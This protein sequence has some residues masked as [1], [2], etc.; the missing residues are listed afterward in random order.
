[1]PRSRS[2]LRLHDAAADKSTSSFTRVYRLTRLLLHIAYGC[3]GVAVVFPFFAHKRRLWAIK[4]WSRQALGVLH[5]R[6]TVHGSLPPGHTP[7]LIVSNHVSW[8]DICL[9]NSVVPVRFVAKSDVRRWPLIGFLAS[10]VGTIFI[11]RRSPLGTVRTNRA[12]AE[13]LSRGE[14][15][16]MFPEGTSTD[17]TE[18]KPFHASLFQPGLGGVARVVVVALRYVNWDGSVNVNA[19]YAGERSLWESFGLMVARNSLHA[20]LIFAASID[21]SG[22]T[23]GDIARAAERAAAEALQ[24]PRPGKK[25]GT[26]ALPDTAPTASSVADIAHPLESHSASAPGPGLSSVWDDGRC[27][28][29]TSWDREP[30]QDPLG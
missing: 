10:R 19:S 9:L 11:E 18:V 28:A 2:V 30:G 4:L 17:G 5:L 26:A 7:T 20:E 12:I 25:T 1:M 16:A 14:H 23:R 8:A 22:K 21:V 27:A 24:L 29:R 13:A 6:L 3:V 15:V